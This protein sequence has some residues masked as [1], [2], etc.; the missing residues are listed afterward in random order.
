MQ[1]WLRC[2]DAELIAPSLWYTEN[3]GSYF[4]TEAFQ[5]SSTRH[6]QDWILALNQ[7]KQTEFYFKTGKYFHKSVFIFK[8]FLK[9]LVHFLLL[10]LNANT[11]VVLHQVVCVLLVRC[12]VEHSFLP[13]VWCQVSICLR[14]GRICSFGWNTT[15]TWIINLQATVKDVLDECYVGW[16]IL[17]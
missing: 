2:P 10:P 17:K 6:T 9:H 7:L 5:T 13:Q 11:R 14:D 15:M 8:T 1:S 3:T 4:S 16:L 12:F